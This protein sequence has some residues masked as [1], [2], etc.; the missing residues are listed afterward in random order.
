MAQSESKSYWL[1]IAEGLSDAAERA[2]VAGDVDASFK[3]AMVAAQYLQVARNLDRAG[4]HL[5]QEPSK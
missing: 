4:R 1:R 3:L 2:R 5:S